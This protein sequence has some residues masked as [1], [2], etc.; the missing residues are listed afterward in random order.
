[1][2]SNVEQHPAPN[3]GPPSQPPPH[4]PLPTTAPQANPKIHTHGFL[5]TF[6]DS[7]P[8]DLVTD[9]AS[10]WIWDALQQSHLDADLV[11]STLDSHLE[12]NR[13][14]GSKFWSDVWA[15][16]DDSNRAVKSTIETLND[17]L[18]SLV[19]TLEKMSDIVVSTV[20][21][22][23]PGKSTL[24][25]LNDR[26]ESSV[27]TR[28]KMSGIVDSSVSQLARH[29]STLQGITNRLEKHS[30][31]IRTITAHN[32]SRDAR[33]L[34]AEGD[35]ATVH[36][37]IDT[38]DARI[39][40]RLQGHRT[41]MDTAVSTLRTDFTNIRAHIIPDLRRDLLQGID[42]LIKEALA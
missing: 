29:N 2:P 24:E 20:S 23:A 17:R 3:D 6:L 36:G 25:S 21:Q 8:E 10:R 28:T 31:I 35:L 15:R 30:D 11:Y 12:D 37:S 1:M 18:E 38:F 42:T 5:D 7:W 34:T 39:D 13:R 27:A 4:L 14:E 16:L 32:E 19:A 22:L 26:L 9:D 41:T 33:V 40:A